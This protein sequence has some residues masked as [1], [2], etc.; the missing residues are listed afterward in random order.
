VGLDLTGRITHDVRVTASTAVTPAG[1]F[2]REAELEAVRR[3]VA[4]PKGE[5]GALMLLDGPAGAGKTALLDG[6]RVAAKAEGLL[7]MQARGAEL[8]RAFAFGVVHQLFDGILR[9]GTHDPSDLFAGAARL[10]APILDFQLEGAPAA[11]PQDPFAARHAL[12]WF[13]A[14]LAAHEPVAILVDDAHW[15]DNTSLGVL[16]HLAQRLEGL[17]VALVIACRSEEAAPAID[18]MR[19]QAA[20]A[21]TLL[22]PSPLGEQATA[23]VVRSFAPSASD[24][25]CR[26]C[27]R[28]SG[29][30]P[31]LLRELARTL[32]DAPDASPD[33]AQVADQSPERVTREIGARLARLPKAAARLARAAA[34]LGDGAPLRQ[35]AALAE[36]AHNDALEAVDALIRA[37]FL[38]DAQPLEFLHPLIRAAVYDA[39]GAATRSLEHARAARLLVD[40]G[41][42]A[43]RIAAQLLRSPPAGEAWAAEQLLAAA[44]QAAARGSA[45][46]AARYLR[47]ALD[48]PP[49]PEHRAR[50]ALELGAAEAVAAD[51]ESAIDHLREALEGELDAE[52]RLRGTMVLAARLAQS[53]RPAEAADVIEEQLEVLA[54]RPDLCATAEA[55]LVNVTRPYETRRRARPVVE[56]LRRRVESGSEHDPAVLSAISVEMVMAAEPADRTGRV[57][58]RALAGVDWAR[59]GPDWSGYLAARILVRVDDFDGALR[60][61]NSAEEAARARGSALD[62]GGALAFRAEL[63]LLIGDLANAEVDARTVL[64]IASGSGGHIAEAFAV[65]WLTEALVERGEL[66]E[67]ESVLERAASAA[68]ATRVYA[69]AQLLL[70]RGRLR[71]AQGRVDDAIDDLRESGRWSLETDVINPASGA[72]RSELAHALV[73][74]GQTREARRLANQEL[75]LARWVGAPRTL[76]VALRGAA[77]VEGGDKEIK[78]LREAIA[79]LESSPA[80]LER[81]RAH[82]ALGAALRRTV[83]PTDAREPLRMAVDLAHQCGA[84]PLEEWALEELRATGA[85]PRRRAATGVEALTASERRIVELA[86]EGQ[87]NRD[88]AQDLF[89]TTQTVEFHL[90]NAYRKL[91]IRS[92]TELSGALG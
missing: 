6:A 30:N 27:H 54:D 13:T 61:L 11:L 83:A 60:A 38:R 32:R 69:T 89:V 84:R 8:E 67:A 41:A 14:N 47:R 86:A 33:P 20:D 64:E 74:V 76:A 19:R 7:L 77:R 53:H 51:G 72:W 91:G 73:G 10:A 24:D 78:M 87:R 1:I 65:T 49:P 25:L 3:A 82:A 88:I 79:L 39:G 66:D 22:S 42:P 81:A 57:A 50:I 34:V 71:M 90:R 12:Y 40:E 26:A 59:T 48:E 9:D 44:H 15:A 35:A 68:E 43:E 28:A 70:A 80:Q 52:Q 62:L 31:F 29:G 21:G 56:R 36:I 5:A 16:A 45:D 63:H 92:R 55:A 46:A 58:R 17:P 4:R 23:A 2:E 75:E 18:A 85:R 37:G